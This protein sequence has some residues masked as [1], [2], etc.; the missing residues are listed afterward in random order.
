MD[1]AKLTK[2]AS[3]IDKILKIVLIILCIAGGISL[4]LTFVILFVKPTSSLLDYADTLKLGD[5]SLQLS[6]FNKYVDQTSFREFSA[7]SVIHQCITTLIYIYG[8]VVFRRIIK[9]MKE[10]RPFNTGSGKKI[11]KL[12]YV[13]IA[14]GLI[15]SL[16]DFFNSIFFARAIDFHALF[17]NP[18]I[19]AVNINSNL[20]LTF[21]A[22]AAIILLVSY[23]FEYGEALQQESDET[24]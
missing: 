20:N 23:I 11:K 9:P 12:G 2:T 5:V 7:I 17:S 21:I 24:L 18:D 19:V 6:Y 14:G 16:L 1:N 15:N 13:V 22:I 10:G 3:V 8:I 4:V